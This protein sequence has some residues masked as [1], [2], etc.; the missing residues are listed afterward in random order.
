MKCK[1][2]AEVVDL[3]ASC[4]RLCLKSKSVVT[5]W[6]LSLCIVPGDYEADKLAEEGGGLP[7]HDIDITMIKS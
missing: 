6:I 3:R 2:S 5:Q 7:Q 4:H 1:N